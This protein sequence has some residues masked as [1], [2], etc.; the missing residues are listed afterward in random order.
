MTQDW[1]K[2]INNNKTFLFWGKYYGFFFYLLISSFFYEFSEEI[3]GES[4]E[5]LLFWKFLHKIVITHPVFLDFLALFI[6]E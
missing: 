2:A 6:E 4:I 1:Y 5:E 3:F